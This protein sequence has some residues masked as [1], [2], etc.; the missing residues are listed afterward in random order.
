MRPFL[1][2]LALVAL[3]LTTAFA[4]DKQDNSSRLD[5]KQIRLGVAT[6]YNRSSLGFSTMWV[7][8]QLIRSLDQAQEGSLEAKIVTVPLK[9]TSYK[10]A[11][12]ECKDRC[13]YI[14][15]VTVQNSGGISGDSQRGI[16]T[17]PIVLGPKLG[18]NARGNHTPAVAQYEIQRVASSGRRKVGDGAQTVRYSADDDQEAVRQTLDELALRMVKQLHNQPAGGID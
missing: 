9:S 10:D 3:S 6:P 8:D 11:A 17:N 15:V 5:E 1:P 18:D 16:G 4:Q 13:D 7:R 2:A 14:L 12:R